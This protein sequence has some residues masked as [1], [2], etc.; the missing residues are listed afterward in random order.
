MP[1]AMV[2]TTLGSL[3]AQSYAST[4]VRLEQVNP[5]R[6]TLMS[7]ETASDPQVAPRETLEQF[8]FTLSPGLYQL[9]TIAHSDAYAIPWPS[10]G[11]AESLLDVTVTGLGNAVVTGSGS[12]TADSRVVPQDLH[13]T[14]L[15]D[16]PLVVGESAQ[17]SNWFSSGS[18][19]SVVSGQK[20]PW[21]IVHS[22]SQ[23][24]GRLLTSGSARAVSGATYQ[25]SIQVVATSSITVAVG[26]RSDGSG[27]SQSL[28]ILGNPNSPGQFTQVP[29]DHW[30][31]PPLALGY[32]F[33]Q[34]GNS[35]FTDILS[36]PVGID[37]D[38]QFEVFVGNQSLGRFTE[39]SSL[40]FVQS[41]GGGVS[42]FRIVG[43]DPAVDATDV[44]AF[45]VKLAFDT[46]F[47][48]F[49]MTPV[50]WRR[51]GLSCVPSAACASCPAVALTPAGDALIGNTSFSIALTNGPTGG[52]GVC[53]LGFGSASPTPLPILCGL[54]Y[55]RLP[56]IDLG[57]VPLT[58][59]GT[60]DGSGVV[61][62][63]I[64]NQAGLMGLFVTLQSAYLC[65][66][67]GVGLTEGIEITI[68]S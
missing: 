19:S 65:P 22:V 9:T 31:D 27:S 18:C 26:A 51:L 28:P 55:P 3:P 50:T 40:S 32:D 45:P 24:E 5:G 53:L 39:G 61:P 43:I 13:T 63:G 30:F 2:L 59:S 35:L 20:A 16:M 1:F 4:W 11:Q 48:D 47:A 41:L 29:S 21:L 17:S 12:V 58:G 62:L 10:I 7:V 38:G 8:Q 57:S 37:G 42:A 34:A 23:A 66:A 52:A 60:C 56:L 67:G 46:P 6:Q 44:H 25:I 15:G 68:G 33:Q 14:V 49:A 54:L 36:L 64:P